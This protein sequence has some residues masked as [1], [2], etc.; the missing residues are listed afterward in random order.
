MNEIVKVKINWSVEEKVFHGTDGAAVPYVDC[1][2]NATESFH[3][4]YL[5]FR[6]PRLICYAL[7]NR[8]F[9]GKKLRK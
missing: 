7:S 6:S 3:F 4:P 5:A 1:T 2:E 9:V 8:V